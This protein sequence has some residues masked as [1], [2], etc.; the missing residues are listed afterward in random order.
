MLLSDAK[1]VYAG[2]VPAKAVY[3]G[4]Q[5]IWPVWSPGSLPGLVTW[6][7]AN[8]YSPGV[9]P[10]RAS[11]PAVTFV[12]SPH[13]ALSATAQYGMKPVRFTVSEGRV[14][15][16]WPYPVDDWTLLYVMRFIGPNP[17]R[18]W[19]VC[20]PPSNLLV[21]M[22]TSGFDMAYFNGSFL[23]GSHGGGYW[24]STP[25]A[26]RIFEGDSD[27]AGNG[28]GFYIDGSSRG[29]Y[30]AG[31]GQGLINGWG[32][33]GYDPATAAETCDIEVAEL[34]LYNRRLSDVDRKQVEDYLKNK[35][36]A[37]VPKYDHDTQVYLNATGLD[38]SFA[39]ILNKLV[40]DLKSAGLWAKM[41]AIYPFIGGTSDLHKWNLKDPQDTDAAY[42]LT[43]LG[44]TYSTH[45][46]L[47]YRANQIGVTVGAAGY[48]TTH[49]IPRN[50]LTQ[51]S[52]HLAFY[53]TQDVSPHD[54][55]EM[56]CF[57][58][59]GMANSR[60]HIIARY[61]GV[62]SYYYGMSEQGTSNVGVP[63][64][65][66]LFVA[67]RTG[68][69]IQTAYRNGVN[70]NSSSTQSIPLPDTSVYIGAINEFANRSDI[71]CGFASIGSGLDDRNNTDLYNIVQ[72]YQTALNRQV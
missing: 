3:A 18:A 63:A 20:Y 68:A 42:R 10:N 29:R 69:T 65:S 2:N 50:S 1:A 21:G 33:S 70:L 30:N 9:W 47:G 17:G 15:S 23:Y 43:F 60:F 49:F 12:G 16:T 4:D 35:W 54:R 25:S 34:V 19:T 61:L 56:G 40:L 72:A 46:A 62:N 28:C 38:S 31:L 7:D 59:G 24:P 44:G 52:T 36:I 64:A 48:A 51:D 67:A 32:L 55:A 13:P 39:P 11:G 14:R 58:W 41:N 66:G 71:P 37:P 45:D 27:S 5:K 22:H 57:T 8:D 6:L 26:W 53:S